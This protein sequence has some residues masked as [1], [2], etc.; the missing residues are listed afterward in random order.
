[1]KIEIYIASMLLMLG[2]TQSVSA[3]EFNTQACCGIGNQ[4]NGDDGAGRSKWSIGYASGFTNSFL[5]EKDLGDHRAW[6][7]EY[8]PRNKIFFLSDI[9]GITEKLQY[10]TIAYKADRFENGTG[11][12]Y[13][14]GIIIGKLD[15]S[16]PGV[17]PTIATG[18]QWQLNRISFAIETGFSMN[19]INVRMMYRL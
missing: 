3:S 5:L 4:L 2:I 13:Y 18:Y 16:T 10:L 11:T 9:F 8:Q 17:A 19:P 12:Y 14:T 7:F 1:M 6:L 15:G